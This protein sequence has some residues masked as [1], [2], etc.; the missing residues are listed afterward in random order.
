[1][2]SIFCLIKGEPFSKFI[3][4]QITGRS[5]I[6]DLKVLVKKEAG[7]SLQGVNP[8]DLVIYNVSIAS[9]DYAALFEVCQ[10]INKGN[11]SVSIADSMAT[12]DS[13]FPRLDPDHV[14][15]VVEVPDKPGKPLDRPTRLLVHIHY[16][17]DAHPWVFF[18]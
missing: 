14:H 13:V 6:Y 1:M 4:V 11:V 15:V 16:L 9:E 5:S 12:I 3:N 8:D 17:P 7:L 10:Q 18:I 2:E